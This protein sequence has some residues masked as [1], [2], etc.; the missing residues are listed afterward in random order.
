MPKYERDKLIR[1][2]QSALDSLFEIGHMEQLSLEENKDLGKVYDILEGVVVEINTLVSGIEERKK[3]ERKAHP[4]KR[5]YNGP[6]FTWA[7]HEERTKLQRDIRK[8]QEEL[9]RI[10]E[11]I[12]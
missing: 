1:H 5:Q 9:S 12:G 4:I 3:E 7:K 11:K 8:A 6:V 2:S 10:E